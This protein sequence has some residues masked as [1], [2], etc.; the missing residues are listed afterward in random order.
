MKPTSLE[1][2][3]L[4]FLKLVVWAMTQIPNVFSENRK[5]L[6]SNSSPFIV[7]IITMNSLLLLSNIYDKGNN[8]YFYVDRNRGNHRGMRYIIMKKRLKI[9]F[10]DRESI[11]IS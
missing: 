5:I 7:I 2:D 11:Q 9:L 3:I 10:H 8:S 6:I 4:P 1:V